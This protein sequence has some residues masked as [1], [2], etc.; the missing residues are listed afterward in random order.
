MADKATSIPAKEACETYK[1][2]SECDRAFLK[3][4]LDMLVAIYC[5]QQ[6][7]DRKE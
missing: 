6:K 1:E 3:A 5:A 7:K 4:V 2:C